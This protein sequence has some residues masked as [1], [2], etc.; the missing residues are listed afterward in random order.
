M[1]VIR[2]I[3]AIIAFVSMALI[4]ACS[5]EKAASLE[6][7]E[8]IVAVLQKLPLCL[9]T[10]DTVNEIYVADAISTRITHSGDISEHKGLKE[11][12]N[13]KGDFGRN[14]FWKNLF[15]KSIKKEADI[16]HVVYQITS[17]SVITEAEVY[18]LKCSAEMVKDGQKWK[19]KKEKVYE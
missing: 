6:G 1:K 13:L 3:T 11:I 16:A 14:F 15:I 12:R 4:L 9:K 19:I 5:E 17:Q 2:T 7:H 8:D 18:T 10:P